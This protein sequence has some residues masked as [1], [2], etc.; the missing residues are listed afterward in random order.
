LDI[1]E[2]LRNFIIENFMFGSKDA[3][4]GDDDSFLDE[5]II[6]STG[7]LEVVGFIEDEFGVEVSDGELVPDNFDSLNKLLSYVN[8]KVQTTS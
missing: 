4:L 6:D 1:K 2:K 5:G 3:S 7:V 8:G